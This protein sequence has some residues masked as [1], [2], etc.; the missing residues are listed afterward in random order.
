MLLIIKHDIYEKRHYLI[1]LRDCPAYRRAAVA[2][3]HT[4]RDAVDNKEKGFLLLFLVLS[5]CDYIKNVFYYHCAIM[6]NNS[7]KRRGN[8]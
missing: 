5:A 8:I 1:V 7:I 6:L 4:P 2:A 3:A